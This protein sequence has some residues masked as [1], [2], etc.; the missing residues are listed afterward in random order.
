MNGKVSAYFLVDTGATLTMIS[1]ATAK[2]LGI[3]LE[4]RIPTIPMQTVAG[5]ANVPVIILDSISVGGMEVKNLTVAVYDPPD[6][7]NTGLLG[8]NFL[9]NFRI[10][11]DMKEGVLVLEK[12]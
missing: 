4:K 9:S 12:R 2:E 5:I 3:D 1:R 10:E 7:Y 11:V 8:L 6:P